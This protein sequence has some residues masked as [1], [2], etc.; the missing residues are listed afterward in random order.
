MAE[1]GL[2]LL[3]FS[4]IVAFIVI[5]GFILHLGFRFVKAFEMIANIYERKNG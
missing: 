5:I 1:V 4:Y 2:M 3:S